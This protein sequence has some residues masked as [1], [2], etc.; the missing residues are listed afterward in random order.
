MQPIEEIGLQATL[1]RI[2]EITAPTATPVTAASS[3]QSG[4]SASAFAQQLAS[5][6][7]SAFGDLTTGV[8]PAT[9][10]PLGT[11][12]STATAAALAALQG[13]TGGGTVSPQYANPVLGGVQPVT[14]ALT[15]PQPV[16]NAPAG[17]TTGT[18]GPQ[19]QLIARIATQELG[20]A[21]EPPGSN[22]GARIA[23]YRTATANSGVGPWCSYFCSWVA[24]QAGVP[25]G[26]TGQGE[27][28]VPN[29]QSWA[30]QTGRWMPSGSET[31]PQAGDLV[32]FDRNGD[33]L[34]DHIGVVTGV[35]PDGGIS[36]V[37]GNS[38]DRVSSRTYGRGE[39]TGIVRLLPPGA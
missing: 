22:N 23:E 5:A 28:W 9:Y 35:R 38:S 32:V 4:V 18:A 16:A 2:R 29:V 31:P 3:V 26:P 8:L 7:G 14:T 27:G 6:Q 37:E 24:A 15:G 30:K 39:W 11:S 25:I 17:T 19:G 34:T 33:G 12:T 36:T 13:T 1:A 20:V 10:T 21:E